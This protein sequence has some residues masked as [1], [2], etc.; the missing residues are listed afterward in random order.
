MAHILPKLSTHKI[1]PLWEAE[2]YLHRSYALAL[3]GLLTG[4][5]RQKTIVLHH[6]NEMP[7]L[8]TT[9]LYLHCAQAEIGTE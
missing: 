8:G 4:I 6:D 5:G 1:D 9:W 7:Q 2:C 3:Q